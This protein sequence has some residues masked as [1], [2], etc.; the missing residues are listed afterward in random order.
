MPSR[1]R[2]LEV[3]LWL[4]VTLLHPHGSK[5]RLH[6]DVDLGGAPE[7]PR[8]SV[9]DFM[10]TAFYES[11]SR[12][13][14]DFVAHHRLV[15]EYCKTREEGCQ[16]QDYQALLDVL[17]RPFRDIKDPGAS[18]LSLRQ[19]TPWGGK[20]KGCDRLHNPTAEEFFRQVVKNR[21]AIISG[22]AEKWKARKDWTW[23]YLLDNLGDTPVVASVNPTAMFDGP[24]KAADFNIDRFE[25]VVGRPDTVMLPFAHYISLLREASDRDDVYY[26]LQYFPMS[27]LRNLSS[28]M[29]KLPFAEWLH[30]RYHLIWFGDGRT[31][32]NT[33][34]DSEE[35]LMI[36]IRGAKEFLLMDP[37]SGWELY[38]DMPM[39]EV[40]YQFVSATSS[41]IKSNKTL[42]LSALEQ[43][44]DNKYS[45]VNPKEPDPQRFP[46]FEK[47]VNKVKCRVEEGEILYNPAHWW[48]H[49]ESEPDAEGKNIG[50][51]M[52][53]EPLYIRYSALDPFFI[54]NRHYTHLH[55]WGSP[56]DTPSAK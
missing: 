29:D 35:N 1:G 45:P 46:R 53:F 25:Y 14:N 42:S 36:M 18:I 4:S 21:P 28:D 37:T 40:K 26:Y 39:A 48:H 56:T 47:I 7:E 27:R 17:R 6:D 19:R 3:W 50:V 44:I 23:E 55:N 34:F 16:W 51:N 24:V 10:A 49:V 33:H 30:R 5:G 52:F 2:A 38:A 15:E 9:L 13:E 11:D 22:V 31:R 20:L 8:A 43:E 54:S 32:G 12:D 41:F